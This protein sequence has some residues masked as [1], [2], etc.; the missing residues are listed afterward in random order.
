MQELVI[1]TN[2]R[3]HSKVTSFEGLYSLQILRFLI[4]Q[5]LNKLFFYTTNKIISLYIFEHPHKNILLK[6]KYD[7]LQYT[8]NYKC[9]DYLVCGLS[10]HIYS[11]FWFSL[12]CWI[13]WSFI[14]PHC[15]IYRYMWIKLPLLPT[16]PVTCFYWSTLWHTYMWQGRGKNIT[17]HF[18][19]LMP[20]LSL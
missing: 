5:A 6:I 8:P 17:K 7:D 9:M 3:K 15:H 4:L 2:S 12:T 16:L 13:Y 19:S 10:R 11:L 14:K 18:P 1:F 20:F